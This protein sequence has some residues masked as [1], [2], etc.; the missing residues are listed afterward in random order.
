MQE[1][2]TFPPRGPS[3]GVANGQTPVVLPG[4]KSPAKVQS[5]FPQELGRSCRL[6]R[7][8]TRHGLAEPQQFRPAAR[9]FI[10][11]AGAKQQNAP[12]A[13]PSEGKRSEVGRTAG[14]RSALIVPKRKAKPSRM[15]RGNPVTP[16][17]R[18]EG[19]GAS[20]HETSGR[21]HVGCIGTRAACQRNAGG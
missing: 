13:P 2:S 20:D 10:G 17:D 9:A 11:P 12:M 18:V 16:G 4:S 15:K 6:H 21:K 14:S 3:R 19:S 5:G 8:T 1:P 7:N